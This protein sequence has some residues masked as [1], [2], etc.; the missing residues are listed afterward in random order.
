M[1]LSS[2]ESMI[3]R[4][5]KQGRDSYEARLALGQGYLKSDHLDQAISHLTQACALD[6]QKTAV[7]QFLG[8]AHLQNQ[9]PEQA[10]QAWERGIQVATVN[11]DEQARKVMT[12][13]LKRLD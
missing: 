11:G 2:L 4:L 13:W 8:E 7:W 5:K 6:P 3:E 1:D 12:V 10:K 9:A